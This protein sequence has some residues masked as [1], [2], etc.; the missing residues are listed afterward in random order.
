[1]E[2]LRFAVSLSNVAGEDTS[3]GICCGRKVRL[4]GVLLA[5]KGGITAHAANYKAFT[6]YGSDGSTAIWEYSTASAAEG[7]MVA[8]NSYGL[9]PDMAPDSPQ[10]FEAAASGALLEF[11]ASE[12]CF[13]ASV[14]AGSGV[15]S[16]AGVSLVFQP[17]S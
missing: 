2:T 1:V 6:V 12:A 5:S 15:A 11:E 10:A 17:I 4:V 8:G 9:S 3:A 16:D 7:S 14:L 13:V